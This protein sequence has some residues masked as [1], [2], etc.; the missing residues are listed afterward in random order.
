MGKYKYALK[1]VQ[2]LRDQ[3]NL[4]VYLLEQEKGMGHVTILYKGA[5]HICTIPAD[6]YYKIYKQARKWDFFAENII[7]KC[8]IEDMQTHKQKYDEYYQALDDFKQKLEGNLKKY[9]MDEEINKIDDFIPYFALYQLYKDGNY[10]YKQI[11]KKIA[12]R[13]AKEARAR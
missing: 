12:K 8:I 4:P 2:D 6:K 10:T 11:W 3:Y 7:Q 1:S 5:E 9:D 13:I